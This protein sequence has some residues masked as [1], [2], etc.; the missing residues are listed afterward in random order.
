M[1]NVPSD[2]DLKSSQIH[3]YD[4][5]LQT[6]SECVFRFC[7]L[8]GNGKAH[9]GGGAAELEEEKQRAR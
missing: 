4:F 8:A 1:A 5:V 9:P 3:P 6:G 2:M 7:V